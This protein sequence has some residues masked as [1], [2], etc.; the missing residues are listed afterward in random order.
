M[1][2]CK[3]VCMYVC[4]CVCVYVCVYVYM[5]VC[6]CVCVYV[7]MYLYMCVC[8]YVFVYMY[9]CTDV[10]VKKERGGAVFSVTAL[11]AGR[12][13][14]RFPIVSKLFFMDIILPAALWS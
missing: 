11:Q 1:C 6:L 12:W 2:V 5:Y 10:C 8:V 4:I 13:R 9:V 14:V 7:R 3:Y